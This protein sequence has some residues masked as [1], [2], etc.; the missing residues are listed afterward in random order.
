MDSQF[1][2][3]T[4]ECS[5]IE[6]L[7]PEVIEYLGAYL[8]KLE[9]D[10]V[11][12]VIACGETPSVPKK[13][14]RF[15][16]KREGDVQYTAIIITPDVLYWV[17][18]QKGDMTVAWARLADITVKDYKSSMEYKMIPDSGID[19]FGFVKDG[20]ERGTVFIGLGEGA[21]ADALMSSL[22]KAVEKAGGTW[23]R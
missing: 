4:N 5:G 19:I 3:T 21:A 8:E 15:S 13:G 17:V 22:G 12:E 16:K 7:K 23:K 2:R 6:D 1:E 11:G 14:G 10:P 18:A 20:R 9:M